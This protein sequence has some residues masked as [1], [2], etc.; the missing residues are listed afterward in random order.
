MP[1]VTVYVREDDLEAWKAVK[2]KAEFIHEALMHSKIPG[3][4]KAVNIK[5][6]KDG[7]IS[8]INPSKPASF[9]AEILPFPLSP[10]PPAPQPLQVN[11]KSHALTT[12]PDEY[13]PGV[14]RHTP[15]QEAKLDS[16]FPKKKADTTY[17]PLDNMP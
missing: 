17:E 13:L 14:Q 10:K 7:T 8:K 2:K 4:A 12:E 16:Y 9:T 15:E 3:L 5:Q 1:Q 11:P 6:N